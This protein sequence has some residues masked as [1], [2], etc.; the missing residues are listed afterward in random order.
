MMRCARLC[1]RRQSGT[2]SVHAV[3]ALRA[4]INSTRSCFMNYAFSVLAV[5]SLAGAGTLAAQNA[6]SQSDSTPPPGYVLRSGDDLEV[7]AYNIPELNADVRIRPDGKISLILLDDVEASG[8]SATQL[9][10]DLSRAFRKYYKNPRVT[11]IVKNYAPPSVYVGG[12]VQ[13]PGAVPLHGGLTAMQAVVRAGGFKGNAPEEQ[14][15]VIHDLADGT[16]Q[17]QTLNVMEVLN[18]TRPDIPLGPSDMVFVPRSNIVVYVGG[19]VARPGLVPLTGGM[20]IL[21][22]I[23]QAG[24]FRETAKT[25]SVVLVRNSGHGTAL[26]RKLKLNDALILDAQTRLQPFD[27]VFVP[28]SKIAKV[29]KWVDQYLK[30]TNPAT[31]SMG[32]SYLLGQGGVTTF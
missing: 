15:T 31:L 13:L 12:E 32:F 4:K 7:R 22:A 26:G 28:K 27:L 24:G 17:S 2:M 5:L 21:A 10:E 20:T 29:D 30:Q 3:E 18:Q 11:V 23:F 14:I 6:L 1:F 8:R 19:E 25:N 9:S 16:H